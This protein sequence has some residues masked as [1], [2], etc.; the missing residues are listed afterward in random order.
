MPSQESSICLAHSSRTVGK[1]PDISMDRPHPG[2]GPWSSGSLFLP[3]QLESG[4]QHQSPT[5]WW[6]VRSLWG[7]K[8]GGRGDSTS[9]GLLW[10]G[11]QLSPCLAD[12]GWLPL[13]MPMVAF[14]WLSDQKCLLCH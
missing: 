14:P 13:S 6:G 5:G 7:S 10:P 1:S 2:A 9:L 3:H 8:G 11:R 4:W 12:E